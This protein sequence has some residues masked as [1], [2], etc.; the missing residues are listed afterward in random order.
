[1]TRKAAFSLAILAG[2]I[3]LALTKARAELPPGSYDKLRM[4]AQ[5]VIIIEVTSVRAKELE[6]GWTDV[7]ITARVLSVERSKAALQRGE[8]I[9]IKYQS[10]DPKKVRIPGPRPLPVLKMGVIYPAFLNGNEGNR[11][12]EPAAFGLSFVMTPE[13]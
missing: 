5:D 4:E 1:M 13:G 11:L 9:T 6:A 8:I 2:T 10:R 7:V 3:G 12:F